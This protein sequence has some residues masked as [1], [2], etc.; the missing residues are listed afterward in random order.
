VGRYEE[1][2]FFRQ[3][4]DVSMR[5]VDVCQR[6]EQDVVAAVDVPGL[7]VVV[8]ATDGFMQAEQAYR[9]VGDVFGQEALFVFLG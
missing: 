3:L 8:E 7:D 4:F 5:P 6:V 1:M 2:S 9:E